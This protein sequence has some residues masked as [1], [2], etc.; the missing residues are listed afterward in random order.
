MATLAAKPKNQDEYS[1]EAFAYNFYRRQREFHLA[2][3]IEGEL[4]RGSGSMWKSPITLDTRS[5]EEKA[6]AL[7]LR[8]K[9]VE[10]NGH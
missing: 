4:N 5:D 9:A 2:R 1:R 7:E 6:I 3:L 8:R 10:A